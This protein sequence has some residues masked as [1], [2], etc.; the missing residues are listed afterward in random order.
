MAP[1][2]DQ[3]ETSA[4][5][6]GRTAGTYV[7]AVRPQIEAYVAKFPPTLDLGVKGSQVQILS[8][9]LAK[10]VR[11]RIGASDTASSVFRPR[12][13]A[14]PSGQPVPRPGS[15]DGEGA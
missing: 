7:H 12:R 10:Q 8:S 9:R 3:L 15:T 4:H 13:A 5:V 1:L 11:G 14:E 2:G 6:G